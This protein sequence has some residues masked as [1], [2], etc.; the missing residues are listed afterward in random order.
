MKSYSVFAEADLRYWYSKK[1][2]FTVIKMLYNIAFRHRI[3]MKELVERAGIDRNIYWGFR[4]LDIEQF[5][6]ILKLGKVD[7]RYIID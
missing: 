6:S 1:S 3:I 2:N 5:N 4:Q 7:E